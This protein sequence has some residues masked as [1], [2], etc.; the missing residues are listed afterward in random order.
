MTSKNTLNLVF[1]TGLITFAALYAIGVAI[2]KDSGHLAALMGFESTVQSVQ[3][4]IEPDPEIED[5][6][7]VTL[8]VKKLTVKEIMLD[9]PSLSQM[10]ELFNGCEITS[11]SM[12]LQYIDKDIDI[13]EGIDKITLSQMIEKDPAPMKKNTKGEITSWGNPQK[14]F[15]GDINGYHKGFGVFHKPIVKLIEKIKPNLALDLSGHTFE[16][17]LIQLQE[18]KPVVV[19][20][21]ITLGPLDSGWMT[22]NTA[23]GPVRGTWKEH[24]VLLVGFDQEHLYINDPLDGSKSKVVN[25]ATFIDSW[26]QMGEQAVTYKK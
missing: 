9:A 17:I 6:I 21:N 10:P 7:E 1:L 19:W 26:I 13:G 25:R 20:T 16:E 12:L 4:E 22:W 15:V 23:E 24:A 5:N 3:E 11:L 18:G 8:E 2:D 14:G